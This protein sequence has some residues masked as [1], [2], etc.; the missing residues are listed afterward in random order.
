MDRSFFSNFR[1][2]DYQRDNFDAFI[3][4]IR[5]SFGVK[6][7]HITGSNGK[8]SVANYLAGAYK[9]N[10]YKVGLF[11][12][13]CLYQINEMIR[14]NGEPISD[15][16]FMS[17][18]NKYKKEISK[19]DLSPFEIETFV[20]L[21]Y[22]QNSG[23][24]IAIIECGMGGEID[25]T[26]IITP[27]LSIIT[28]ISLEH[29]EFLGYTISEIT[30]QKAGIIKENVPVLISDMPEDAMTVIY[31][32]AKFNN[33]KICY[34]GHY[35]HDEFSLSGYSFEYGEFGKIELSSLAKYSIDNC[36]MALESLTILKDQLPYDVELVR[37][38]LK[39]VFLP[40]QVEVINQSPLVIV[41]GAHNQEGMKKLCDVSLLKLIGE[42]PIHVLFACSK[43]KNLSAMLA[44]IGETT[45]DLTITTYDSPRAR[46]EEEYF[47]FAEDYP[48][49]ADA[50]QLLLDKM[51]EFPEDCILISGSMEFAS[52]MRQVLK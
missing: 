42:R 7:I 13:P 43:D 48:F 39:E 31:E 1:H 2:D 21:S 29:T 11:T 26:N 33:S 49:V 23:C 9:A 12:S 22:F 18:F 17:I 25:A 16:D 10:N 46:G 19:F 3:K 41:D 40:T 20:A 4:A 5:F 6:S 8:T 45:N 28:S 50:K 52:Y 30:S 35:V 37:K 47:L 51:N 15:D 32:N 44:V 34:L 14:I 36:V 24:D 38:G 27:I